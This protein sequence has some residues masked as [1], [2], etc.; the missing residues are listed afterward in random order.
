MKFLVNNYNNSTEDDLIVCMKII[1]NINFPYIPQ[2]FEAYYYKNSVV[3][4][5]HYPRNIISFSNYVENHNL[6]PNKNKIIMFQ[7]LKI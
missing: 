6:D 2:F 5:Y 4:F 1:P 3:Y 7:L